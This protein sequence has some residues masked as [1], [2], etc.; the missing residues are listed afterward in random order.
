MAGFF[1]SFNDIIMNMLKNN[2]ALYPNFYNLFG[3]KKEN[4]PSKSQELR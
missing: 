3:T 4:V 1:Y 2:C